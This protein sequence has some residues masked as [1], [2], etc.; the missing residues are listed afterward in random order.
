MRHSVSLLGA[1]IVLFGSVAA[2]IGCGSSGSNGGREDGGAT[3]APPFD[4]GPDAVASDV[5][6]DVGP[7]SVPSGSPVTL[8]PRATDGTVSGVYVDPLSKLRTSFTVRATS[9]SSAVATY[10]IETLTVQVTLS[11]PSTAT[12]AVLDEGE[13]FGASVTGYGPLPDDYLAQFVMNML[14]GVF[15][16]SI[17]AIPLELNCG[18]GFAPVELAALLVP[19]QLGYKYT[20]DPTT[21]YGD[22]QK[23]AEA[24]TCAT[25]AFAG[26]SPTM[27]PTT[28]KPSGAGLINLGNDDP[29]PSVFGFFP[30]DAV[31][32]KEQASS[33]SGLKPFGIDTRYGPCNSICRGACGADCE[34]NNCKSTTGLTLCEKDEAGANTCFKLVYTDYECG[35]H[36]A[37]VWHDDCY[38]KCNAE[39]GCGTWDA[40][41]CMHTMGHPG[42]IT[43]CDQHVIDEYGASMGA[44]WARGYGPQTAKQTFRYQAGREYDRTMC[45]CVHECV[46]AGTLVAVGGGASAP[47][48]ALRAGDALATVDPSGD[49]PSA[50]VEQVLVHRDGPYVLDRLE[51]D[52]GSELLVTPNHPVWTVELGWVPVADLVVGAHVLAGG[53]PGHPEVLVSIVRAASTTD[54]VYN[55]KTSKGSYLAANILV[56]NKCLAAGS[57]VDTP[58]GAVAIEEVRPGDVVY[59]EVDGRRVPTRVVRVYDKTTLEG[60]LPGRRI[61][62]H[63]VVTDNHVLLTTKG[64]RVASSVG[65]PA[66]DVVGVVYD[67]ETESGNYWADGV[68]L[69]AASR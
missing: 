19:W 23:A 48:E 44:G 20:L 15:A 59:G 9:E 24:A 60:R 34:P 27:T 30:F 57:R 35:T 46:P 58:H 3:D 5:P 36:P 13:D 33:A 22:T 50:V 69:R 68:L 11:G 29:F 7:V 45:P 56:H 65:A 67:L 61:G 16:P 39:Y 55:L 53:G 66:E 18:Q 8:S 2:A 51:T 6:A 54:V 14:G 31:G 28:T 12:T 17:R 25:F 52:A 43:S 10:T 41:F 40:N 42:G 38:D 32:E 1:A 26:A 49:S 37:C 4:S 64:E 63:L 21:R 62:A 47:I